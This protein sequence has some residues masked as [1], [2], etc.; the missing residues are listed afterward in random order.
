MKT[1]PDGVMVWLEI[2]HAPG[3]SV[4]GTASSPLWPTRAVLTLR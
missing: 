3:M 1:F 4:T 2:I